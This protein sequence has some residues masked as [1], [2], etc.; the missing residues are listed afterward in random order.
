MMLAEL[1]LVPRWVLRESRQVVASGSLPPPEEAK[2]PELVLPPAARAGT[3]VAAMNWMELKAAVRECTACTLHSK[4]TQTVFGVGDEAADW[5][6]IGEGPGAEEDA[7]GE[8]FVG[9]AG[10]LLDNMLAA[11]GLRRGQ[12]V[13]IANIVK[14]RPPGNRTPEPAEAHACESYLLRQIA[15]LRPRLL[16]ALGKTAA[17]NLLN[18]ESS[19]GSLRGRLHE[20]RGLPLIVTYHPAYLLRT[21]GDKAKAWEDLCFARETMERLKAQSPAQH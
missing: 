6:F 20:W 19:I 18:T 8:P 7:R 12:D 9:Q 17:S 14:C 4:R 16:I 10:R 5:L 1:G 13:Y 3:G 15:L 2:P 21:L 11:I